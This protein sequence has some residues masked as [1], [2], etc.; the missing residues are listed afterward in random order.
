MGIRSDSLHR[1]HERQTS[2]RPSTIQWLNKALIHIYCVHRCCQTPYQIIIRSD[3]H[4]EVHDINT[5]PTPI[6]LTTTHSQNQIKQIDLRYENT[7]THG[8]H[9]AYTCGCRLG[10]T[11]SYLIVKWLAFNAS[12]FA[13][14]P[15]PSVCRILYILLFVQSHLRENHRSG[16]VAFSTVAHV[17]V[18][19]IFFHIRRIEDL[20]VFLFS[21]FTQI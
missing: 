5:V 19:F 10:R 12:T 14:F 11:V 3:E 1:V 21:V 6:P 4:N 17:G 18:Y 2:N 15:C 20:C 7:Y 16:R 8:A 9:T 13:M